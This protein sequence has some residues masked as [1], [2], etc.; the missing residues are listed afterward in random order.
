MP[1]FS[2]HTQALQARI[3]QQ[4]Q[5]P[6]AVDRRNRSFIKG[7]SVDRIKP[8]ENLVDYVSFYEEKLGFV[9]RGFDEFASLV[10]EP[11]WRVRADNSTTEDELNEWGEQAAVVAG[12]RHQDLRELLRQDVIQYHIAGTKLTEHVTPERTDDTITGVRNILPETVSPQTLPNQNILIEPDQTD[13]GGATE[14]AKGE[15]AAYIQFD[16]NSILGR[17]GRLDDNRTEV[18]LSTN[19]ISKLARNPLPGDIFGISALEPVA[20][21]ANS[22]L[23]KLNDVDEAIA[24]KAYGIWTWE[25][26]YEELQTD[27]GTEIVEWSDDDQDDFI[28]GIGE[29]GPGDQ[30]GHDGTVEPKRHE[31]NVPDLSYYIDWDTQNI[32]SVL[33]VPTA[34]IGFENDI[35]RDVLEEQYKSLQRSIRETRNMLATHYTPIFRKRARQQGLADPES[36]E[37]IIEPDAD[38]SPIMTLTEAEVDRIVSMSKAISNVAPGGEAGQLLDESELRDTLLQFAEERPDDDMGSALDA[39]D[40]AIRDDIAQNGSL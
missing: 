8:P 32:L 3:E 29:L 22:L 11:G 26:G 35:N 30:I 15:A 14:T 20:P 33:P 19:D 12:E 25:F 7:G 4:E 21:R 39:E 5:N 10:V 16:E 31:G 38:Q 28:A 1:D 37:V 13:L 17:M 23:R 9:H 24:S 34:M 2:K 6:Q 36:V 18:P 40:A 27:Q